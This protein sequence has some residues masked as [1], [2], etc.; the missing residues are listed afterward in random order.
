MPDSSS[1]PARRWLR[2]GGILAGLVVVGGIAAAGWAA[3]T[4]EVTLTV[5]G[6]SEDVVTFDQTVGELLES[7]GIE[8]TED[9]L[10]VPSAQSELTDGTEVL[11]AFA[12]EVTVTLDGT[13]ET[14]TTTA[15]N[16]EDLLVELGFARDE[17]L[18][19][20]VSRSSGV[21]RDGLELEV[22]TS[23]SVTI[24]DNGDTLDLVV[25]ATTVGEVLDGAGITLGERDEVSPAVDE[26]ASDGMSIVIERFTTREATETEVVAFETVT[27]NTDSLFV[28]EERVEQDGRNGERTLTYRLEFLGDEQVGKEL[29]SNE[30]TTEPVDRIVLVGTKQRPAPAPE[31]APAPAPAQS[32]S[33]PAPAP[34]PASAPAPGGGVWAALAQCESGG[35]WSINTGNGFY[36]GLQFTIGTWLGY[37]G[38]Q[39]APRADLATPAQQ[40]EI[41]QRVVN[42]RGGYG[43][44]PA[45]SARLGLPR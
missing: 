29:V 33:A 38:G 30:V 28:G 42:A 7:Q 3:A 10:V 21:P 27:R 13:T 25:T 15:F 11:V 4:S 43:D 17:A 2:R 35:N 9:D 19:T 39:Y 26:P 24:D 20:S 41:A 34:A 40:I 44:W 37:G 36:G 1:R 45:C 14:F 5:E 12:R 16:V 32:S 22:R 31:P 6:Q 18:T 8:I 23:K